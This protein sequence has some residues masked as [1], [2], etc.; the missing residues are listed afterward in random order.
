M[1]EI[2]RRLAVIDSF[3]G[4]EGRL[5]GAIAWSRSQFRGAHW[6]NMRYGACYSLMASMAR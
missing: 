5:D 2:D 6:A 3:F 1:A 4:Q